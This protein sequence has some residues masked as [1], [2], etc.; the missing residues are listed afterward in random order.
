M[1]RT[2]STQENNRRK[3]NIMNDPILFHFFLNKEGRQ[4]ICSPNICIGDQ[5]LVNDNYNAVLVMEPRH[6]SQLVMFV[7]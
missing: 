7:P 1:T 6:G 5:L 3:N 4:N 2:S